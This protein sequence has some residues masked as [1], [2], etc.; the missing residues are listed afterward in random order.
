MQLFFDK[1]ITSSKFK[2]IHSKHGITYHRKKVP[3]N[4]PHQTNSINHKSSHI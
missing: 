2:L 1:F 4:Y 3:L